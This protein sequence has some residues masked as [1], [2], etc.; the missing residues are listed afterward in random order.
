[1]GQFLGITVKRLAKCLFWTG[2]LKNPM[3]CLW[4]GSPTVGPTSDRAGTKVQ[5]ANVIALPSASVGIGCLDKIFNI[6]HNFPTIKDRAFIFHMCISYD[7]TFHLV[8]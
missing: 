3:K 4:H 1:M 6:G 5:G 7:E 8:P 2:M